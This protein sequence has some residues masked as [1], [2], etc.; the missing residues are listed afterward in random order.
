MASQHA[1]TH[2]GLIGVFGLTLGVVLMVWFPKLEVVADALVLV[3][4]FHLIGLIVLLGSVYSFAPRFF[5]R[6]LR[7]PPFPRR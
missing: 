6:L 4:L 3:A 7:A 1:H 5:G 2:T